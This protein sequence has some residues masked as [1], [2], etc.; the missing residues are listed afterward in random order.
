MAS[1]PVLLVNGYCSTPLPASNWARPWRVVPTRSAPVHVHMK[2]R[3]MPSQA[4]AVERPPSGLEAA[5]CRSALDGTATTGG[6]MRTLQASS[7]R[8][9]WPRAVSMTR[10]RS[11]GAPRSVVRMRM[12]SSLKCPGKSHPE[13]RLAQAVLN[14]VADPRRAADLSNWRWRRV[15]PDLGGDGRPSHR[16][17][18]NAAGRA[19]RPQQWPGR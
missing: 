8:R 5:I 12:H 1:S 9:P 16:W 11:T 4:D 7:T 2:A 13:P 6:C 15:P 17:Q 3:A 18:G 19:D 10:S 14:A